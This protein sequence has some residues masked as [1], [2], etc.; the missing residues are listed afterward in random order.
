MSPDTPASS[1]KRV[2]ALLI[3]VAMATVAGRILSAERVYEPSLSYGSRAPFPW[4]S[5][6]PYPVPTF[7]S[8]DRSRWATIRNLV[9]KGTYVIGR[10]SR[11]V[12]AASAAS[13]LG[14]Q[15]GVQAVVLLEA[16]HQ[17]RIS[18]KANTG[19]IFQDGYES[20][21]KVM[22]PKTLEYYSSKP[23]LLSTLLAGEYWLLYRLGISMKDNP[24]LVVCTVLF[25][26]QWLPLL[27]YLILLARLVERYGST[28]WGRY[29]VLAAGGFATMATLFAI[30]LN[31][32]TIATC[33][34]LFALYPAL[35][36]LEGTEKNSLTNAVGPGVPGWYFLVSGF[37][38]GFTVSNEMPALALAAALFL[39]LLVRAPWR[40][41]FLYVPAAAVPLAALLATNYLAV[42]Q[43]RP[44]QSEFGSPWYDYEGSHWQM[45]A[46]REEKRG[47]DWAR[48]KESRGEYVMHV[49]VGHHGVFSLTPINLLALAGM[50]LGL[51]R[52][53]RKTGGE[54]QPSA[55]GDG[56]GKTGCLPFFLFPLT[57]FLTVVVTGFYL[58][59]TDNYGGW[60]NG[61]RWLMWLTPFWLLV[62]LPLADRL[63]TCRR[64][65]VLGYVLLAVSIMSVTY[66]SWN[67]WRM[68]WLYH[69]LE[70][71]G[72][73]G[74]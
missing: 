35:G 53:H 42:G 25:T 72:W 43:L 47:V 34:A 7:G 39:L 1:R 67:P 62:M 49:L 66:R 73:K 40:T 37:F 30:T 52:R 9:E 2:Y 59:K 41:L 8:N 60:T 56:A 17:A 61:P 50:L 31:N 70:A 32:H 48:L 5:T 28:D 71:L 29:F 45:P 18:K 68:P 19:I 55:G 3:T 46:A 58:I 4:P 57:L 27:I 12:I 10:R 16:G 13:L 24:W 22:D 74:Y 38:A 36:I 65:R 23:P 11:S 14:S 69:L 54:G 20:V 15:N 44:V 33:T 6:P 26:V 63:A 51:R 21:D 64:G